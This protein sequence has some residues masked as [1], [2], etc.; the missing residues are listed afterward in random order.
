MNEIDQTHVFEL[1]GQIA[2]G[3]SFGSTLLDNGIPMRQA[4]KPTHDHEFQPNLAGPLSHTEPDELL[5]VFVA[6]VPLVQPSAKVKLDAMLALR[7]LLAH[8]SSLEH[9]DISNNAV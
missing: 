2:S 8:T 1:L 9:L 3:D 7:H 5:K 4:T 6:F